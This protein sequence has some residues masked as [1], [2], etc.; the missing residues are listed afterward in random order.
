MDIAKIVV[1]V[2]ANF[3]MT[4]TLFWGL[5]TIIEIARL[6]KPE[7]DTLLQEALSEK[8]LPEKNDDTGKKPG[9]VGSFSRISGAFGAMALAMAVTGIS[10]WLVF[11]LFYDP[12]NLKN[13]KDAGWFFLAGSALFAPYAFN[14]LASIFK[15]S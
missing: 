8:T 10:Y 7:G 13:L 3:V 14:Q 9:N 6:K 4:L 1:F 5:R 2:L 12:G 11:A 15:L